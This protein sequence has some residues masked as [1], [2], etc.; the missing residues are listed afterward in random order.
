M[1]I[2]I[3]NKDIH[4]IEEDGTVVTRLP[5][6][7]E[8]FFLE[9]I[10]IIEKGQN[11]IR[12]EIEDKYSY[13]VGNFNESTDYVSGSEIMKYYA[14]Q[15]AVQSEIPEQK[16]PQKETQHSTEEVQTSAE[17]GQQEAITEKLTSPAE[18]VSNEEK[19]NISN[20]LIISMDENGF[21]VSRIPGT[22]QYLYLN[23]ES[24]LFQGPYSTLAR[25]EGGRLYT[26][27]SDDPK[28]AATQMRGETLRKHYSYS[29]EYD[30]Q[31]KEERMEAAKAERATQQEKQG[32]VKSQAAVQQQTAEQQQAAVQTQQEAYIQQKFTKEQFRQLRLGQKHHL[33]ITT[34]WNVNLSPE[35]M[36]ELRLMQENGV[37]IARYGYADPQISP[38]VLKE[39]R[40]GH[41]E[42]FAMQRYDWKNLNAF[43]LKEIRLGLEHN[44][45]ASKYA[46]SVYS[47]AQM[48]Q[49][50]LG[51]Q[52]GFDITPYRN[53]HF[54]SDQMR[55]M[56][57]SQL[58]ERIKQK[59]MD[60]FEDFKDLFR[61]SKLE[62][63]RGKVKE[64]LS[65]GIEKTVNLMSER[66]V[67]QGVFRNQQIPE[68]TLE[69]RI[70]E[71]V[72]DIKELL[73][74]QE[75]VPE[76]ILTDEK[77]SEQMNQRIRESLDKLMQ[78]E[79]IQNA[80]AQDKIITETADSLV[81][82]TG[83]KLP[84]LYRPAENAVEL[85]EEEVIGMTQEELDAQAAE[86]LENL[87]PV[88][89]QTMVMQM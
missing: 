83:A 49:L 79:N 7:K 13:E 57:L 53:I 31:I 70:H 43:Q 77:L 42:G 73:V 45:D 78:P 81:Q 19:I 5:G 69:D 30:P 32:T 27:G 64:Q 3:Y 75:L 16:A 61:S 6:S 71:T 37:N 60:L 23:Q 35:Q 82:E 18:T 10:S 22:N 25:I 63:L 24:I 4:H 39:L 54:T 55:S 48:K 33:D 20:K 8:Y 62:Q 74:S 21:M 14:P 47:D 65:K 86:M 68:E 88:E 44:I 2:T 34:Y 46:Y 12:A 80:E 52:S 67:L 29:E 11:S 1:E 28:K 87:P 84:V 50:R 40:I 85:Q 15:K 89:G 59:L 9:P 36:K 72:Q 26:V 51:L 58:F 76:S 17:S 56:R 38:A 66:E 41:K